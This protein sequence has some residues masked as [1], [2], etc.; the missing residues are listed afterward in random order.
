MG[1]GII[2]LKFNG[3]VLRYSVGPFKYV[4]NLC[5]PLANF[6]LKT[7]MFEDLIVMMFY[8][9][10]DEKNIGQFQSRLIFRHK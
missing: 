8:L 3:F 9:E 6:C 4:L 2:K 1:Y 5:H 10:G 7:V